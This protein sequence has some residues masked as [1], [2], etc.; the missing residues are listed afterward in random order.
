MK[1]SQTFEVPGGTI[2]VKPATIRDGIHKDTLGWKLRD[3]GLDAQAD[4][5][6]FMH[7]L[8]CIVQSDIDGDIGYEPPAVTDSPAD[9]RAAYEAFLNLPEGLWIPWRDAVVAVNKPTVPAELRPEVDED[10]K[11]A[12]KD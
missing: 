1:K 4:P 5:W 11:K 10:V 6:S 7:F 9:V 8:E 3:S 2:T 12:K